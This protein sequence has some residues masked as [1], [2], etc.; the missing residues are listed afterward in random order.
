MPELPEVE[1][2]RLGLL[3]SVVGRRVERVSLRRADVVRGPKRPSDLLS[4]CR[5]VRIDRLGKQLALIGESKTGEDGGCVCIHLGMSGSL[6]YYPTKRP[7]DLDGHVHVIWRLAGSGCLVFRDPRR[8]GG[9]WTYDSPQTLIQERWSRLGEDALKITPTHLHAKLSKTRRSTKA[10]LLDQAVIAGLGNIYVDELLFGCRINPLR[11]ASD[12]GLEVCRQMVPQM[13]RLLNTAI[14][15]GGSTLRNYVNAEGRNGRFQNRH[16]VYGR[17]DE[18][19]VRCEQPLVSE[20][21]AGRTT[22]RCPV[23]QT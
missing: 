11:P 14:R 18:P 21:V 5:V 13:R 1:H 12:V 22:V 20:Q 4:G 10:A 19:C 8:F 6:R 2:V 9:M 15:A 7:A 16:K 23:C 17:A 3:E